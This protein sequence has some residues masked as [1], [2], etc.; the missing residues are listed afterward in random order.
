[1]NSLGALVDLGAVRIV[2]MMFVISLSLPLVSL[3]EYDVGTTMKFDNRECSVHA[4]RQESTK[5]EKQP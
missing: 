2:V 4:S 3:V 5:S 1:M